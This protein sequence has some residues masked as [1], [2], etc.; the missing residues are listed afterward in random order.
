MSQ[1]PRPV[2]RD[3]IYP[4]LVGC[5][6]PIE[7]VLPQIS[8]N[9][10][11]VQHSCVSFS[12]N[13]FKMWFILLLGLE[14]SGSL[15]EPGTSKRSGT[16]ALWLPLKS[17]PCQSAPQRS[18]MS[19]RHLK[20]T[21]SRYRSWSK[22]HKY[23]MGISPNWHLACDFLAQRTRRRRVEEFWWNGNDDVWAGGDQCSSKPGGGGGGG[24]DVRR[25][26]RYTPIF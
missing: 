10:W 17:G 25:D 8:S 6:A 11:W 18:P 20:S 26:L 19:R 1:E 13:M 2:S 15:S 3:C 4:A 12:I 22:G 23:L 14:V 24:E 16:W 5:S 7:A 9:M 21:N